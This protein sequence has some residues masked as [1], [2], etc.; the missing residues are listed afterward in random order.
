MIITA[1]KKSKKGNILIYA[2]GSYLASI[3][4]EVFLKHNLKVGGYIDSNIIDELNGEIN[5]NKAKEKALR[6]LSMRAHS[7]KELENKITR[8]L[9]EEYA[10]KASSKMEELGLINDKEFAFSYAKELIFRKF[11]SI[12]RTKLELSEKGVSGDIID[13]VIDEINPDEEENIRNV[14]EKRY[15]N[16]GKSLKDEKE[17]KKAVSY[18]QR[19]GYSWYQ[20]KRVVNFFDNE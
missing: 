2:D 16:K 1:V 12:S 6:L 19:L 17:L 14:L 11:H 10:K 18:C 4:P 20:I 3:I 8:S 9:G 5:L 15:L 13:L 7:K